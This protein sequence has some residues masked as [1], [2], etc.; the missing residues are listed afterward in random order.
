MKKHISLI[1]IACFS[2]ISNLVGQEVWEKVPT[3]KVFLEPEIATRENKPANY[4]LFSVDVNSLN[5]TLV[6]AT[7]R[8]LPATTNLI[9]K[10]PT[11]LGMQRFL[12][13]EA[14]V[15]SDGL[16]AKYPT[17]KSY[18]GTGIDDPTAIAR[19][20]KSVKGFHAMITS[21]KYP[22]YLIDP[23]TKDKKT[24]IAYLKKDGA[25][26]KI[27]CLVE[28]TKKTVQI[29]NKTA[30]TILSDGKLRTY[31][32]ALIGTGEYSQFHL[33]GSSATTDAD[34]K[35]EVL[36]AMNTTIT[37]V[38]G[39]FE[40]DLGVTLEIVTNNTELIFLDTNTDN[41]TDGDAN[42]LIEESQTVCDDTI[43]NGMYDIGHAFSTG[44]GGLAAL[45]VVC[46]I[47][48]KAK[49][50]TGKPA[51]VDD[52][53]DIDYVAHELGHQLGANH[54]QNNSCQRN[55]D[56]AAEPGS[57]STIMGYA[58]I[59]DPNIQNNS[60]PYFHALSIEE[61]WNTIS[62]TTCAVLTDVGNAIPVADAGA[63]FVIPKS[64]AF[65]L[66][67]NATD[68]DAGDNLT[69]N[70]EQVDVDVAP[71]MPP[72]VSNTIGPS[73]RSLTATASPNRFMPAQATV[74]AGF[75]ASEWEVV[76]S[77]GRIYNFALTVRDNVANGGAVHRDDMRVTSINTAG[78]FRITSHTTSAT[79]SGNSV[80]TVTWDVS[81]TNIAPI[82]TSNVKILFS[83]D[84]GLT[85]PTTLVASTPNNGS[86]QVTIP[87]VTTTEARIKIEPVDNIYYAVNS[88]NFSVDMTTSIGEVTFDNFSV[89]PN[90]TEGRIKLNFEVLSTDIVTVQLFDLLGRL[91]E[92]K[93]FY[94]T[95]TNFS[96]ELNFAKVPS[97]LYMLHVKNGN[98]SSTEKILIK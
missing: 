3:S 9:M 2:V 36:A 73:F 15:F 88:S 74:L 70:W 24:S 44:A 65:V 8:K 16:A 33:L 90:P 22:M 4:E 48:S 63:D 52:S 27:E 68:A 19:F 54:T 43:G 23:Y 41:L 30:A 78:P 64:T 11:P 89:F 34:K 32:L 35:A 47:G 29:A 46:V 62:L 84:G 12:V 95:P 45:G 17:I 26:S 59:C 96:E 91:V 85:F 25:N 5:E 81:S 1:V 28:D 79:I 97:G 87:N 76:S 77:S 80:E 31:R 61:I 38:N 69:Y 53:F 7:S 21:T 82:S 55:D 40:I 50:V 86:A 93:S 14:S 67:G 51:P 10:L 57:A 6:N 66:F 60:D 94:N 13:R 58:G 92:E 39:V 98:K 20:S 72:S 83:T 18:V 71:V 75:V 56:T 42:S 37:R 49:G